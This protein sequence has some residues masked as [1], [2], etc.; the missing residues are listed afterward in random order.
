MEDSLFATHHE[1][2]E[3]HWWFR[4]RRQ[5][6]VRLGLQLLPEGGTVVDVGC[7]TGADLAAFSADF[8]RHGLDLSASAIGFAKQRYPDIDFAVASLPGAG[9]GIVG[10][11]DLVLLCD[12]LEH[13]EDDRELLV[14]LVTTMKEGAHLLITVPA[15]PRLWSP[16][17]VVYGHYRRYTRDSLS[18]AWHGLPVQVSL[19][20]SFNR[21]LFPLV[22][23]ARAAARLRGR[24]WGQ[25]RSDLV[26]PPAPVNRAL[27]ALFALEIRRL[28]EALRRRQRGPA[29]GSVSLLAVL[30][31]RHDG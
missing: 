13:V 29:S 23:L 10:D 15:D 11:A 12:V 28:S 19:L 21:F 22:R 14:W 2:E 18:A 16:H 26:L 3:R 5:A 30:Q 25:N 20:A 8:R 17:D 6:I 1:L 24:G 31:V 7:G 9:T 4:A 27:E